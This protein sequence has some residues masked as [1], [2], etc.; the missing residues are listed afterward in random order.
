MLKEKLE[1]VE[2]LSQ[3]YENQLRT[4][5]LQYAGSSKIVCNSIIMKDLLATVIRLSQ[6]DSTILIT[7]ES[8]TGKELIA[9]TIHNNSQRKDGSYIKVNCGAIPET[10]SNQNYSAMIMVPSPAQKRKVNWVI[11]NWP[12]EALFSWMK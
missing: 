6:F 11:F 12:P 9:E 7:G 1:K 3:H 10:C 5:R 2:G 8:G 4:L